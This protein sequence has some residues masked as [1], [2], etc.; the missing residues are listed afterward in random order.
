MGKLCT[1]FLK[2]KYLVL[3]SL[4]A[5]DSLL[6]RELRRGFLIKR[7]VSE[8]SSCNFRD[9]RAIAARIAKQRNNRVCDGSL[10]TAIL[11]IVFTYLR[12]GR[13]K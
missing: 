12:K 8:E 1:G 3:F 5:W 11:M 13:R 7:F 9:Q 6:L 4:L 2:P 10:V